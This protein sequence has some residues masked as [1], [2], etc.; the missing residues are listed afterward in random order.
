MKP[1]HIR[2]LGVLAIAF[3]LTASAF[4]QAATADINKTVEIG[5]PL[6]IGFIS[7]DGTAPFTFQWQKNAVNIPGQTGSTL[8]LGVTTQNS[9]GTYSL[10][11]SNSKGSTNSNKVLLSITIT[12]VPSN[13]V[14]GVL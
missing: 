11:V 13:V 2:L 10:V 4:A 9:A 8:D 5:S 1:F 3:F 12:I 7:A 6:K 14:I